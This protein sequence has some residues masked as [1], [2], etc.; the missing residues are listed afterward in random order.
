MDKTD[1]PAKVASNAGL[2]VARGA[3]RFMSIASKTHIQIAG[4]M[5]EEIKAVVYKHAGA[6]PLA[7]V[8]GVLRIVERE[9]MD[10]AG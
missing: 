6:V 4:D 1:T 9:L 10:E 8:L 7:L 2:G 3:Q 5:A